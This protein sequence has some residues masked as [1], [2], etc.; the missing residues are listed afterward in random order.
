MAVINSKID[1][2]I[3]SSNVNPNKL[4]NVHLTVFLPYTVKDLFDVNL[5]ADVG[6]LDIYKI[7]NLLGNVFVDI[8]TGSVILEQVDVDVIDVSTKSGNLNVLDVEVLDSLACHSIS[9]SIVVDVSFPSEKSDIQSPRHMNIST[10][11]GSLKGH[12]DYYQSLTATSH[13]G[14]IDLILT[15]FSNSTAT[16]TTDI[17]NIYLDMFEF[18]GYYDVESVLGTVKVDKSKYRKGKSKKYTTSAHA[19]GTIGSGSSRLYA[20]SNVGKAV[21]H[22]E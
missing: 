5:I 14:L 16:T 7:P 3:N 4:F 12:V 21:V 22:F 18:S 17:G 8:T 20:K 10:D 13:T 6:S 11:S 1:I 2:L 15:S 19:K 9:G